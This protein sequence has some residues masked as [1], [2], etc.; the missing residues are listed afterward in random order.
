MH[1]FIKRQIITITQWLPE[2]FH[3]Q[4]FGHPDIRHNRMFNVP[5]IHKGFVD[6]GVAIFGAEK[7]N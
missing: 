7:K 1:P 6:F 4:P 5:Y 2:R 3:L